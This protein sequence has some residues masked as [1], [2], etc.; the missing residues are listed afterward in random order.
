[1]ALVMGV[2]DYTTVPKLANTLRDTVLIEQTLVELDF[3]V[4]RLGDAGLQEMRDALARFAFDAETADVALFYFAGHGVEV[5]GRNF[6]IPAD[7]TARDRQEVVRTSLT[8]DEVL[9][10]VDRAR[11]LRIVIL[12]SCRDDPFATVEE[13]AAGSVKVITGVASRTGLA[14]PS[15]E[16]GTLVAFAAEAGEVALDGAG[17]NSPFALSLAENMT[18]SD[19]EIGLMFRRVRDS[20]LRMTGNRQEPHTYGSLPGNPYF[21]AGR[22]Q[23]ANVLSDDARRQAWARVAPDQLRQIEALAGEGDT[24][25]LKGLAYMRLNPEEKDHDPAE[26]AKLLEQAADRGDPEA[27]FELGRLFEKGIGVAQDVPRALEL[28]GKAADLGFADA[29]NDLGFLHFQGGEGV[30]RDQRKALDHFARAAE[31]RHPEA[32]FNYAAL[33]DDGLVADKGPLDAARFLYE[34]L[35]SGNEDVL[36]QLSDSPTMFKEQTRAELQRLLAEVAMYDGA[37][38]GKFGPATRRGLRQAYGLSDED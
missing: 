32:M 10:A 1:M 34:A 13:N 27:M 18:T 31:L 16:R 5:G 3:E 9:A 14:K 7:S 23:E 37:I 29:I 24:R 35:R 15:P 17:D 12:D 6:L 4:R 30:L 26:G 38:D 33:I 36:T 11:Q 25:A 19:L 8:L 2:A 22:S 28:F 20:V 21:L